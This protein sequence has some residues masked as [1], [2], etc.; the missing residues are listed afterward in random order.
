MTG[1]TA[2]TGLTGT[3]FLVRFTAR[4]DRIR[5]VLWIVAVTG[6]VLL[7]AA[8]VKGLYPTQR[9]L[10]E[11]AVAAAGNAAVIA[12]NG[13]AQ[14]L[15]TIGGEVAFQAGTMGLTL[16]GLMSLLLI[17]RYTRV[18]EETGRTEL[19][20]ATV[21]G[22]DAQTAAALVLVTSM[23]L[24][25]AVAVTAGLLGL[26]LPAEGS[27]NFGASFLAVGLVFTALALVTGQVT[28]NSRVASGLAGITLG[29]AFMLRAVGDIHHGVLSWLSPIG[30]VQK[31]RPYAG[32]RWWPF[33]VPVLVTLALLVVAVT[34][35][36]RRD[37]GAGLVRPRP[38]AFRAAP[39]LGRTLGLAMRLNRGNLIG[40]TASLLA[41]GVAYGTVANDIPDVVGDNQTIQEI[42]AAA[43]DTDLTDAYL[44]TAMLVLALVGCCFPVQTL[45]RLRTEESALHTEAVLATPTPRLRW[46]GG[47]LA[48]AVLGGV[49]VMVAAGL[50][51]G[52][53]YAIEAGDAEHVLD[54]VGAG[55][56]HL[57]AIGVLTGLA[58]A[59][60]G[61]APRALPAAWVLLGGCFVVGFLGEV[62]KLPRWVAELSPFQH[63]PQLPAASLSVPPLVALTAI[64][65]TLT[66]IGALALRRRDIG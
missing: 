3:W 21:L 10:D 25:I 20:R 66:G 35:T 65:L 39:A 29:A 50:G 13:P 2:L 26:G 19:M 64:A 7:M 6:L 41:L 59:L 4:R 43:G 30:W 44:G 51:V 45:Q 56:A 58:A 1:P 23:N 61:L 46:L 9:D 40:W 38:G 57:P 16:V 52:V 32:E 12:F 14:G 18:E 31:A 49:V 24:V 8:S 48:V 47:H 34:L 33:V 15:D 55:L 11:A 54:L 42:L 5:I 63:T 60:Y 62:L 53:P 17:V 27:V 22:R 37:W 36:A 28:E